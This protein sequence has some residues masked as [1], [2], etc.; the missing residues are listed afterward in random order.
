MIIHANT[1][2]RAERFEPEFFSLKL[3]PLTFKYKI[4]FVE[5]DVHCLK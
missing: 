1:W 5:I 2:V 3:N 4:H